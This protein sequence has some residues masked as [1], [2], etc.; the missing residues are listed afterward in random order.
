V[1]LSVAIADIAL[2]VVFGFGLVIA[3]IYARIYHFFYECQIKL[4]RN[5]V[6]SGPA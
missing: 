1:V 5:H 6:F 2:C 3:V 4:K